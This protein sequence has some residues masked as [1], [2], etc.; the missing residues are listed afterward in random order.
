M[1]T[2]ESGMR[3]RVSKFLPRALETALLSYHEFSEEQATAP[4][5]EQ[6]I[7]KDEKAKHF[8]A[9]HDAC[10]VALAHIELLLKLARLADLPDANG[11]DEAA[12]TR[13]AGLM[14]LAQH[15]IDGKNKE[16]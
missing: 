15:E 11:G 6:E 9:H 4:E 3:E 7:G 5:P 12:R 16:T 13:M 14:A 2:F 10:K 8:K 1:T